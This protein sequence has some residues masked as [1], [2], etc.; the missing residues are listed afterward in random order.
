[1]DPRD[2]GI[3]PLPGPAGRAAQTGGALERTARSIAVWTSSRAGLGALFAAG[4][5]IRLLLAPHGG[6]PGDLI[7][8]QHWESQLANHDWSHFIDPQTFVYYPYLYVLY[9][10][11]QG[12]RFILGTPP[13]WALLKL[14]PIVA[15]LGLAWVVALLAERVASQR[16]HA[17]LPVRG[18][19][20]AAILLNPPVIFVSA[21]WGQVDSIGAVLLMAALLL[22][23]T[24]PAR[25]RRDASAAVLMALAIGIKPQVVVV[26]PVLLLVLVGRHVRAATPASPLDLP[27]LARRLVLQAAIMLAVLAVVPAPFG[28]DPLAALTYYPSAPTY[29]FT[30]AN[31]FNLWGVVGFWLPDLQ[32]SAAVS[33]LGVPAFWV[34]AI[35]F[36]AGGA[37]ILAIC[38]SQVRRGEPAG[39]LMV[40]GCAALTCLSVAVLTRGHERYLF[41]AIPC[42]A[43]FWAQRPVRRAFLALSGLL[44][45]NLYYPY[46]FFVEYYGQRT[47]LRVDPLYGLLFGSGQ[48]SVEKKFWSL[49]TAVACLLVAFLGWR[50]VATREDQPARRAG[51]GLVARVQA[52][53]ARTAAIRQGLSRED[54]PGT[55]EEEKGPWWHRRAPIAVVAAACFFNLW[56]LNSE[57]TPVHDLNDSSYHFAMLRWARS[58]IQQGKLPFDGWYPD[59]GLGLAQF[60]HYQSLPHV[61]GGYL[62]FLFGEATTFYWS[63]YLLLALWPIS[64]Y[65]CVRLLGW[66][67]WT[68][69]AAALV[70]PLLVSASGYGYESGTYTWRGYGAWSQL[71]GMWV[72]PLGLGLSWRAVKGVG[73]YA[74]ASLAVALTIA[75]HFLTG[76]LAL[77]TVGLWAVV[78]PRALLPRLGRAAIV[79]VGAVVVGAWVILPLVIDSAYASNTVFERGT[80]FY[81]S[82]GAPTVIGWLVSGQIFDH[83]RFPV[84]SLLVA[85]GL[86]V[87][88]LRFRRDQRARAALAFWGLSLLLFFGRPTLGPLLKVLPGSDDLPLHRYINGVHLGGI[89][90]AGI[91]AAWLGQWLVSLARKRLP[92]ASPAA[93]T[94]V[95]VLVGVAALGPAWA[96]VA[97]IDQR[98]ADWIGQQLSA[99]A[100]ESA[101]LGTLMAQLKRMP[102]GRV[103]AG[104]SS[105]WGRQYLIGQVPMYAEL[106]NY[107]VDEIGFYLRTESLSSDVEAY[108]DDRNPA[109]YDLYNVRYLL[110]PVDMAPPVPAQRLAQRGRHALWTVATSGYLQVID[111]IAPPIIADRKDIG[112][113]TLPF[114][115]S[116]LLAA[117][118]HPTVAFNGAQAADPTVAPGAT[119]TGPA[120]TVTIE[121]ARPDDGVYSGE[122]I[123]NRV[124]VVLLKTTFEPRWRT[125]I[126]GIP[127]QPQMIAPDFVGVAVSPGPHS[128]EFRYIPI[129]YY[130][131]L[132]GLGLL[133]L[134]GLHFGPRLARNRG[135]RRWVRRRIRRSPSSAWG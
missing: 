112:G 31:A 108:F 120:G 119:P 91:G 8:F 4:L 78:S 29:A 39:G 116:P 103:Y 83:G 131:E 109:Q 53:W 48:D 65:L 102:P 6:F 129:S 101:D 125:T 73:S 55:A 96:E 121:V 114:T 62:S 80:H 30:S 77:L 68:A 63:L 18:P 59:L 95:F 2:P 40:F 16:L 23:A 111:T 115:R 134:A 69:A 7:V 88:L 9:L 52:G 126:D 27:A 117:H 3:A 64:V 60:H 86:V 128:I 133:A 22:V 17:R 24:G 37:S 113:Q 38:W 44:L 76:Y 74:L 105:N 106:Q 97:A 100:S 26:L 61:V 50:W 28:L 81:D 35:L 127:V 66:D 130:P 67:R 79:G 20:A 13:T 93:V 57:A 10:L 34:G 32:G 118:L 123:A 42:L 45:V 1:L 46:V 135:F 5:V 25:W 75:V 72:L 41:M 70:A 43:V 12:T 90:I 21:L 85:L 11:G 104:S 15:D 124:A 92:A 107:G 94:A 89:I 33:L 56:V 98:G 110:L 36:A 14:P 58:K 82:F 71:W 49:V 47:F 87:C 51:S 54:P 132:L 84:V 19:A 99:D 122:I